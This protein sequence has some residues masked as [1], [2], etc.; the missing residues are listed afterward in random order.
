MVCRWSGPRFLVAL[1][2]NA[3]EAAHR[4]D[5]C[6]AWLAYESF[7]LGHGAIM[8]LRTHCGLAELADVNARLE[9]LVGEAK[10]NLR[11]ARSGLDLVGPGADTIQVDVLLLLGDLNVATIGLQAMYGRGYRVRWIWDIETLRRM[12]LA[13]MRAGNRK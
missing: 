7:G 4:L 12:L 13:D 3:R 2:V 11:A 6:A 8:S 9:D 1:N 5:D 10:H